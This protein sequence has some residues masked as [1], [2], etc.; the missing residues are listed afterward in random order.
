MNTTQN[1]TIMKKNYLFRMIGVFAL[2]VLMAVGTP[3]LKAQDLNP[4]PHFGIKGGLNLS[5]FFVD[6]PNVQ[7]ENM[8]LGYH[9]GL[10]AKMPVSNLI[11][12]QPELLYT[13]LGSRISYGGSD[14]ENILGIDPGEVRFNLNYIQLPV[15]LGVNLGPVNVHAGP[16]LA[17]LVS[18]NVTDL[19]F[20][21]LNSTEVTQ[22]NA[23]NFNRLDYGVMAGIGFDVGNVT[24]GAR[25]NYGL[26]EVGSTGIA[27]NL[28]NN[29][30]NSVG[31]IYIG[32]GF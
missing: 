31:Q 29:S 22:L 20:S 13:N 2:T 12:V 28:T 25:Y 18:A 17:Y 14:L 8:K 26:R 16:Y 4:G 24:L 10:F 15:A 7:D 11:S 21:E 5:Q 32:F 19:N 6:Q 3:E 27:G 23:D 30:R 1:F 9:F